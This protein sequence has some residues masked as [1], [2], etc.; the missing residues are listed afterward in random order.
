M[1][2]I[3]FALLLLVLQGIG[4]SSMQFPDCHNSLSLLPQNEVCNAQASPADRAAAL[5]AAMNITE[6]LDNLLE[7]SDGSVRLGLPAYNWWNEALHGVGYS[8]GVDFGHNLTIV[9]EDPQGNFSYATSFATPLLLAAAF[10]DEM[11]YKVAEVISTEARAFSNAGRAGLDYWTPNI[12]PYRDP[13]WGR[14]SET[15]GE[16]PKRIKCYA[17]EF[18]RGMEGPKDTVTKV[19][20]TC[21][22]FAGYD[23]ENWGGYSRYGFKANITMQDLVEY[24]LPPFQQCARDSQVGSIMCSYNMVNG[25]PSCGNTYLLD[26]ILRGHWNWT[27]GGQYVTSDCGVVNETVIRTR[28]KPTFA[29]FSA[30]MFNAGTDSICAGGT[31][32]DLHGAYNQSLLSEKTIDIALQRQYEALVRV[33]YFGPNTTDPYTSLTWGD[34]ATLE[35]EQLARQSAAESMVMLKND[36]TLPLALHNDTKVALIGNWANATW[37]LLGSYFGVPPFYHGPLYAAQQLGLK[38]FYAPGPSSSNSTTGNWTAQINAAK[39]A[40]IVMF[41]GGIDIDTSRELVDRTSISWPAE[42]LAL[43]ERLCALGKPC[44]VIQLGEQLDDTALLRNSNISSILWA[45][46]PG[47]DGGPAVFDV[48]T[49]KVPPAGRLPV[50]QYPADYVNQIPMSDMSLRPKGNRP[51]R[52]YQFY[53]NAVLPFGYGLHYTN[54]SASFSASSKSSGSGS[55]QHLGVYNIQDV[56]RNC[57]AKYKD[58]CP[59]PQSIPVHVTNQGRMTSDFVV[60]AFVSDQTTH[61]SQHDPIKQLAAYT[62]LRGITAGETRSA[63]LDITLGDLARV[64]E[65][66]DTVLYPGT[67]ELLL[68]VPTQSKAILELNGDDVVLDEWPQP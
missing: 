38:T 40:D 18:I 35:S 17:R 54:F 32:T 5:V 21:K 8:E 15:P 53:T 27:A 13:R 58:L 16:D 24:Y 28:Y 48:L 63:S 30:M 6:K 23:L 39:N 42:Q 61:P 22:H 55:P 67:Y 3:T 46:Y 25:V 9:T 11:I 7:A 57:S 44:I 51:G 26:T 45:M 29:A 49:G 56:I 52:T 59:L 65:R 10:D 68:D 12:N 47:Q 4:T 19:V 14:G 1:A 41:F 20:A 34:V 36:G 64:T 37:Q 2:F 60:L 62:R 50:T 33:G 66:G 43:V 31:P